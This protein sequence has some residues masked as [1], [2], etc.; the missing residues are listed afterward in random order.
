MKKNHLVVGTVL[1]TIMYF[2]F[3]KIV[4]TS[5]AVMAN[6]TVYIACILSYSLFSLA[7]PHLLKNIKA[8]QVRLYSFLIPFIAGV[9]LVVFFVI[10]MAN[11]ES[12]YT[13]S[14][15]GK[16]LKSLKL[17]PYAL[18]KGLLLG[19]PMGLIGYFF[20]GISSLVIKKS[21]KDKIVA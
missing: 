17:L 3:L 9:S 14:I 4:F 11:V 19:L 16:I 21:R 8:D 15:L 10:A 5:G 12:F 18:G 1:W 20:G 2:V 13:A 6:T 7:I